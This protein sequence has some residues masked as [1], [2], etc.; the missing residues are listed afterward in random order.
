MA[1]LGFPEK[2]GPDCA[3]SAHERSGKMRM[4]DSNSVDNMTMSKKGNVGKIAPEQD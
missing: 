3:T 2:F 4:D 1:G